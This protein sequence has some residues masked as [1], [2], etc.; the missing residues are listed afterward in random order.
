M[1]VIEVPRVRASRATAPFTYCLVAPACPLE[2]ADTRQLAVLR[3]NLDAWLG[4]HPRGE[5]AV[6]VAV[7]LLTNALKYGSRPGGVV[8]LA[9]AHLG[10]GQ[11]EIC[12][13]DAGRT[14]SEAPRIVTPGLGQ[15]L[16]FVENRCER[17]DPIDR[18]DGGRTVRAVLAATPPPVIAPDV[19]DV[20]A[21][22]AAYADG[23]DDLD[24]GRGGDRDHGGCDRVC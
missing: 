21:L 22:I 14:A 9:V 16:R 10:A 1:A 18:V 20:E 5:D 12:V 17:V 15:G 8:T 11:L 2:Q 19:D 3:D 7:E 24:D 13:R 4:D 23:D 6:D